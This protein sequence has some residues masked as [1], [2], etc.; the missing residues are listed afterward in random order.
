MLAGI[1]M[2]PRTLLEEV[3]ADEVVASVAAAEMVAKATVVDLLASKAAGILLF[4]EYVYGIVGVAMWAAV[5]AMF[6]GEVLGMGVLMVDDCSLFTGGKSFCMAE[7]VLSTA[8]DESAT[9]A[10]E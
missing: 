4:F 6:L 8:R 7:K 5:F 2:R 10:L 1:L 9:F 3:A